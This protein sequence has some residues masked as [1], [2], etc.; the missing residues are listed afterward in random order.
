MSKGYRIEKI[1]FNSK[2]FEEVLNSGGVQGLVESQTSAICSR[3]NANISVEGSNGYKY[4]V[5]QGSKAKRWYGVVYST[6]WASFTDETENKALSRA[7]R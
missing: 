3:A 5:E 4:K 2:G 7:V 6:N 1:T